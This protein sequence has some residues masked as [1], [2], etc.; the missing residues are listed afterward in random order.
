MSTAVPDD[1]ASIIL[2][3]T[4]ITAGIPPFI[5]KTLW[6]SVVTFIPE[7]DQNQNGY[8]RIASDA[9]SFFTSEPNL[10][11]DEIFTSLSHF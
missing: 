2:V 7:E 9:Y 1:L 5:E 11:W 3:I 4:Y 6:P 10:H 8:C